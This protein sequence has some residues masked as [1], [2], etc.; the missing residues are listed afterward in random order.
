MVINDDET[1]ECDL[2]YGCDFQNQDD[3]DDDYGNNHDM[4]SVEAH[5]LPCELW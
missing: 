5:Y 4:W 2:K 1:D 3:D